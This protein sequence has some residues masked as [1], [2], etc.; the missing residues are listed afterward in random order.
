[1]PLPS[2]MTPIA[3]QTLGSAAGSVTFVSIPSTYTDLVL[4]VN[5]RKDTSVVADAFY[6]RINGD[7]ATNYSWTSLGGN[8]SAA[9]S[10]TTTNDNYCRL[11]NIPGNTAGTSAFGSSIVNF[12]NYSNTTTHKTM[13]SR[14]STAPG[15]VMG[16]VTLWRSTAAINSL[17]LYT[18]GLG[19]WASG[20]MFTL[21][22]IKAA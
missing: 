15:E 4:I 19:N 7:S 5:A 12:Q 13:I 9:Y 14:G 3:T 10:E 18:A 20:S 1:M 17:V 16:G 21:Y 22:G 8:G 11:A 6:C 2:T